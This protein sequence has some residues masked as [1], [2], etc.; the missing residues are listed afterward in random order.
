MTFDRD[1][2]KILLLTASHRSYSL[3]S[4]DTDF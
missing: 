4:N 3:K 1:S 2:P